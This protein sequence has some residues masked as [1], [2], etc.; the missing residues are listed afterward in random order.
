LQALLAANAFLEMEVH[1]LRK[2]FAA[3]QDSAASHCGFE[4]T[5]RIH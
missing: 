5:D 4:V 1:E 3:S 2:N